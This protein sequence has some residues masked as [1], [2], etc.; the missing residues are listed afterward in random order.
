MTA[1]HTAQGLDA[2][3]IDTDLRFLAAKI[4]TSYARANTL[5]P[6]DLPAVIRLAY[7][8]LATCG[9]QKP[10]AEPARP[11]ARKRGRPRRNG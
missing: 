1:L 2:T 9:T 8:G 7:S 10:P 11:A 6:G 5:S 4:A 3:A